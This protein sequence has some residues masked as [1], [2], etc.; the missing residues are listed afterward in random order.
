[1]P[2]IFCHFGRDA[3]PLC[4]TVG[5]SRVF[6]AKGWAS[7]VSLSPQLPLE[8]IVGHVGIERHCVVRGR[9]YVFLA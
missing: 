2:I 4:Y 1:M 5:V 7:K 9:L 6:F 3:F 8:V